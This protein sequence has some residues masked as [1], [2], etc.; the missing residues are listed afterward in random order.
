M[1][2]FVVCTCVCDTVFRHLCVAV[3]SL[4]FFPLE[5]AVEELKDYWSAS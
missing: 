3:S 1:W 4:L 2:L 5:E